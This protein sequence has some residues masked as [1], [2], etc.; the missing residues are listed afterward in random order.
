MQF[1]LEYDGLV[2]RKNVLPYEEPVVVVQERKEK[3]EVNVVRRVN[4]CGVAKK[5][6]E[7]AER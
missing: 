3:K 4:K 5:A 7:D 6:A 2:V 1:K